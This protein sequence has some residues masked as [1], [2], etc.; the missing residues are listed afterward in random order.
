[1][2]W[3]T[4][5]SMSMKVG[6]LAAVPDVVYLGGVVCLGLDN[7][8]GLV[9]KDCCLSF[10]ELDSGKLGSGKVGSSEVGEWPR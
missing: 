8:I 3:L 7:D 2:P 9:V 6:A 1:M 4:G 10:S 5:A